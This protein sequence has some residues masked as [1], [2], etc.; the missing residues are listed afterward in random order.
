LTKKPVQFLPPNSTS[1]VQTSDQGM[2]RDA[3]S[4]R[5]Q[6]MTQCNDT[7]ALV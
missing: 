7:V 1:E 4:R 2:T 3:K 5:R 6:Q